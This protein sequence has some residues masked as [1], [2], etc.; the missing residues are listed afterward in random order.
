MIDFLNYFHLAL[1]TCG[2]FLEKRKYFQY[3]TTKLIII[4]FFYKTILKRLLEIHCLLL[5]ILLFKA[6]IYFPLIKEEFLLKHLVLKLFFKIII[7]YLIRKNNH[8][9]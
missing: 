7:I 6:T 4:Q 1:I 5:Y 3:I 9:L 8:I 2:Q